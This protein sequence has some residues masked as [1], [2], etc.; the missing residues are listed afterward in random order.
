VPT[1]LRKWNRGA[2]AMAVGVAVAIFSAAG[3]ETT[4]EP[5]RPATFYEPKESAPRLGLKGTTFTLNGDQP[6]ST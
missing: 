2:F 5:A 1:K 3:S 4:A 6:T